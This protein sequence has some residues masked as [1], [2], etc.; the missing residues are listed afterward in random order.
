MEYYSKPT[1]VSDDIVVF[2]LSWSDFDSIDAENRADVSPLLDI[3]WNLSDF[4]WWE[5]NKKEN[6]ILIDYREVEVILINRNSLKLPDCSVSFKDYERYISSK[7][8]GELWFSIGLRK[9]IKRTL[10]F[11]K[12]DSSN[13]KVNLI[14]TSSK[15]GVIKQY[16]SYNFEI[17]AF[18]KDGSEL[19]LNSEYSI[20]KEITDSTEITAHY[21]WTQGPNKMIKTLDYSAFNARS[22]GIPR[23]IHSF[24]D[25]DYDHKMDIPLTLKYGDNVYDASITWKGE[26][27]GRAVIIW[28]KFKME[29]YVMT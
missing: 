18:K 25:F 29:N 2:P 10:N 24:F 26:N 1:L 22:S 5:V 6:S 3:P 27:H 11:W 20:N 9:Y 23:G 8:C 13:I 21:S 12:D 17:K 19:I 14:L 4:F 16:E 15:F 7:G 28:G